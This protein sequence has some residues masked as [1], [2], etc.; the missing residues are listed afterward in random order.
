MIS[1]VIAAVLIG[2]EFLSDRQL[3]GHAWVWVAFL[4]LYCMYQL[5]S[6]YRD[7]GLVVCALLFMFT[8]YLAP[9]PYFLFGIPIV[10]YLVN[11]SIPDFLRAWLVMSVF[12]AWLTSF[13]CMSAVARLEGTNG[14]LRRL[15][16]LNIGVAGLLYWLGAA[17]LMAFTFHGAPIG[18]FSGQDD[19]GQYI[20]NLQGQSGTLEYFLI[21]VAVGRVIVSSK[22]QRAAYWCCVSFYL[23]FCLTRGFR[24]QLLEM[25]LLL[26]ALHIPE[27]LTFGRVVIATVMGFFL[28]QAIGF[29][30]TGA[31]SLGALFTF[32][33]GNQIRSNQTE[34]FY[35]TS[36]VIH[37]LVVGS[38]SWSQ[39]L[40]SLWVAFLGTVVPGNL[41]PP[42]W[43]T[44][45]SAQSIVGIE[46]GGGG[47]I[48]GHYFYWASNLGVMFAAAIVVCLFRAYE[49]ARSQR[50]LL[51]T[52][53]LMATFPRWIAYEPVAMFFRAGIYLWI[54]YELIVALQRCMQ[55]RQFA[56]RRRDEFQ[57]I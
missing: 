6:M 53:L 1:T 45:L 4:D 16:S 31:S 33:A 17:A 41:L 57:N 51:I 3:S 49:W 48:A 55:G 34:V 9:L 11:V 22:L 43:Q 37:A 38:I 36:S 5:L 13:S 8:Y 7:T 2:L 39:R 30:K 27:K 42:I 40:E 50:V 23:Y 56:G 21:V 15:G 54:L 19:Y 12:L 24:V 52:S 25:L 46:A 26:A 28:F 10:P 44:T 35:T 14:K 18:N 32:M 47:F 29:L 20:Q